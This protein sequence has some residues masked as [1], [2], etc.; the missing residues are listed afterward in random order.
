[1]S[2]KLMQFLEERTLQEQAEV[3]AFAAFLL[4]CQHLQQPQL[5]TDDISIQELTKLVVASGRFD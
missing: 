1:M 5:L 4:V 3:E 2:P